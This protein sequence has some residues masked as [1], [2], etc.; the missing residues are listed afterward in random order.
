MSPYLRALH[1]SR[2]GGFKGVRT[3]HDGIRVFGEGS[4]EDEALVDRD[5]NLRSRIQ[6]CRKQSVK[7]NKAK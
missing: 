4:L 6:K 2:G 1:S 3:I 5:R 7:L